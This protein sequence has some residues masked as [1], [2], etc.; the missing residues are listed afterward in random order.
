MLHEPA[1]EAG[2]AIPQ[3]TTEP[4]MKP[5]TAITLAALL[6]SPLALA[7]QDNT[8]EKPA[9][10]AAETKSD[11]K[12]K[13]DA[14]AAAD[15]P[16]ADAEAVAM[17]EEQGRL[18][19]ENSL[20]SERLNRELSGLRAEAQRL[21]AEREALTEGLA[22]EAAKRNAANEKKIAGLQN[23]KLRL[24]NEAALAKVQAEK[25][26][27]ELKAQQAATGLELSK[28]DAEIKKIEARDKRRRF[29][30]RE[31]AYLEKPLKDDGTL[32][33][34]DRRIPLNGAITSKTADYVTTR[35][36]Y[37]NNLD[38]KLPIFIVIDE[39]PG[40][41]VLAGY[42]ILKIMDSSEAPIHVV[43]KTFAASMAGPANASLS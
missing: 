16:P 8:T 5:T 42:R 18:A 33:I 30:T 41:S 9:P 36:H 22:L 29:V 7:I 38:P 26:G 1:A 20:A 28:L 12:A 24:E 25:L 34:S 32:V 2:S 39:S 40:G 15:A 14:K 43:L 13:P 6:A 4:T 35:I 21:K 37:Y 31:P 10:A 19:L 23:D 27:A 3:T 17:R 11:T